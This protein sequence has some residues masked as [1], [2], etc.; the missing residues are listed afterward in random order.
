MTTLNHIENVVLGGKLLRGVWGLGLLEAV[1][2]IPGLS[3]LVI[4]IFG[5]AAVS[6]VMT[7][8]T[9][10]DPFYAISQAVQEHEAQTKAEVTP[11]SRRRPAMEG[12]RYQQAA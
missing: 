10:W 12:D 2:V 11:L 8:V 1:L 7:A 9:G 4:A 5:I 3:P 6:L